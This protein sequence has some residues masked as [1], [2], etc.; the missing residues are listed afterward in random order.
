M[1]SPSNAAKAAAIL[2]FTSGIEDRK[3][4][5]LIYDL[6][7]GAATHDQMI[8]VLDKNNAP[9]WCE[10]EHMDIRAWWANVYCLAMSIDQCRQE[11]DATPAQELAK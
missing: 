9:V 7:D 4:A 10:V 8:E 5:V 2:C 6:L 1:T 11:L 3:K